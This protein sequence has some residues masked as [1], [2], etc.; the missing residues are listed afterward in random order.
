MPISSVV[1]KVSSAVLLLI[2]VQLLISLSRYSTRLAAFYDSRA[3]VLLLVGASPEL[4]T[5]FL[6]DW[7]GFERVELGLTSELLET[8]KKVVSPATRRE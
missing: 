1:T 5:I 8:V 2:L 3:D 4:A 6:P 7:L